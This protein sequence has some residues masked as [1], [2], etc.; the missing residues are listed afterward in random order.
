[1]ARSTCRSTVTMMVKMNCIYDFCKKDMEMRSCDDEY[2]LVEGECLQG[3]KEEFAVDFA[4][5]TGREVSAFQ[6]EAVAVCDGLYSEWTLDRWVLE[7]DDSDPVHKLRR[8]PF[9]HVEQD[10]FRVVCEACDRYLPVYSHFF[11]GND[12]VCDEAYVSTIRDTFFVDKD[13]NAR[14]YC[15]GWHRSREES[16]E[17]FRGVVGNALA[18]E[19]VRV[20][21][22]HNNRKK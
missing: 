10:S 5:I 7:Y 13:G 17:A 15:D 8:L 2:V 12:I 3:A 18:K 6:L 14:N 11:H 21:E 1:M 20:K 16:L 9:T 19:A 22:A 4:R